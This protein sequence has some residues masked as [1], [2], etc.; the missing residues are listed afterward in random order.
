MQ[1]FCTY[2]DHGF[3]VR[4][5][6]LADSIRRYMPDAVLWC[7]CFDDAAYEALSRAPDPALRPIALAD[8][9]A[10]DPALAATQATRSRVEFYFT[11]TASLPL[12]VLQ[13]APEAE[14]V[15]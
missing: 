4:A 11:C 10:D 2:F 15:T 6:A 9:L 7:L 3:T 13:L 5:L 1:H 8:F 14:L 12:Y